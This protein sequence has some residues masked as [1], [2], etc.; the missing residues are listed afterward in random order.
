[1]GILKD[2]KL[3]LPEY[4]IRAEREATLFHCL[5]EVGTRFE[6][7]T[8]YYADIDMVAMAGHKPAIYTHREDTP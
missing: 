4:R 3:N 2:Y 7:N 5:L 8:S 6:D 1:L